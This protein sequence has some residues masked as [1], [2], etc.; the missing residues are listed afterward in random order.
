MKIDL[1]IERLVLEGLPLTASQGP[2]VQAAVESEL[3]HLLGMGDLWR[4]LR[5]GGAVPHL[6]GTKL[7]L[8]AETCPE[9]IGRQIAHSVCGGI[10]KA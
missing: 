1:H 4:Q 10:V 9:M 8:T 3:V 7:K 6:Q 5:A 2:S